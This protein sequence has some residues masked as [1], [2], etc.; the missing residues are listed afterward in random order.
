MDS[1]EES[2]SQREDTVYRISR[3]YEP[4]RRFAVG[5]LLRFHR[6]E[7]EFQES[8]SQ[9][10]LISQRLIRIDMAL[11]ML[12]ALFMMTG[13]KR[14]YN[15][16][17]K[18]EM[19]NMYIAGI[20]YSMCAILYSFRDPAPDGSL[21]ILQSILRLPLQIF[22][23]SLAMVMFS[24]H[25]GL[26]NMGACSPFVKEFSALE[27]LVVYLTWAAVYPVM[28]AIP[29]AHALP[30][31]VGSFVGLVSASWKEC[32]M[33]DECAKT[34]HMY[35]LYSKTASKM[36]FFLPITIPL[37]GD[38]AIDLDCMV[39]MNFVKFFVVVVLS[40]YLTYISE[41]STRESYALERGYI[42]VS[43]E[44]SKRKPYR[45]HSLLEIFV[46]GCLSWHIVLFMQQIPDFVKEISLI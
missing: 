36:A 16:G 35:W 4:S 27:A 22:T 38:F 26:D 7:K 43:H 28:A 12:L 23:Y 9:G 5:P 8:V 31:Q 13:W 33:G 10:R 20:V 3:V 45:L 1:V 34:D 21:A 24:H 11:F 42:V 46:V 19:N 18:D 32:Q 25:I 29:L 30:L 15:A 6:G 44:L 37:D 2:A 40:F 41:L 17:H 14:V 39:V